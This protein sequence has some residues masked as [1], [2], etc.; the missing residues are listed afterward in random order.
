MSDHFAPKARNEKPQ[1]KVVLLIGLNIKRKS[2]K[3]FAMQQ[4][5]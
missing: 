4:M 5:C 2:N 1:I 3:M